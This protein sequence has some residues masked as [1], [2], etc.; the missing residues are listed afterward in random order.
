MSIGNSPRD[1]AD[2]EAFLARQSPLSTAYDAI[3]PVQPP[4]VLDA[5]ILAIARGAGAAAPEPARAAAK[6]AAAPKPPPAAPSSGVRPSA[7][8]VDDDDDEDAAP[9]RRPRWLVPAALAA[10]VLVAVG[11]SVSLLDTGPA[12]RAPDSSASSRLGSILAKRARERSEAE[13]AT[14]DAAAAAASQE[15]EVELAPLPPPPFFEP[16]GPQVE[17]LGT[18][19]ALIRRE[20][21]LASQLADAAPPTAPAT[22]GVEAMGAAG[23]IQPRDRRLAKILELFD[24]G[25]PDLAAASLEIFL[26]D[27]EDDP[28]SQRIIDAQPKATDVS[29]E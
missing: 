8:A 5:K 28:I 14:A 4:E 27:F 6:P 15:A 3:E 24:G 11:V 22:A 9:A 19:I 20:L 17:D 29:V 10:T 18:A 13:K 1:E 12:N 7:V 23:V 2:F 21:V 16:E 25:N 26:R